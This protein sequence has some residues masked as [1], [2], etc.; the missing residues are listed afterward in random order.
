MKAFFTRKNI[1]IVGGIMILIAGNSPAT[2]LPFIVGTLEDGFSLSRSQ[3]GLIVS[4][5]L[6]S[7]AFSSI[8]FG[9]LITKLNL[10]LTSFLGLLLIIGSYLFSSTI[11]LS[12]IHI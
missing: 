5:E 6:L 12:L 3:V 2:I 8:L 11:E 7:I 9:S 4:S 10:K 1:S